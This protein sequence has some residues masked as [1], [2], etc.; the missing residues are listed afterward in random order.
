MIRFLIIALMFA[1]ALSKPCIVNNTGLVGAYRPQCGENNTWQSLQ[2]HGSIGYC[3]CVD[4]EGNV[5][6]DSFRPWMMT[7]AIALEDHCIAGD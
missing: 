5:R 3:W 1:F 7:S 4:K 2:C 6:G